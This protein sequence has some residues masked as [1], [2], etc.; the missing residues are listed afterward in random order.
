MTQVI[1]LFAGPGA[2]KSTLATGVFSILKMH[3]VNCEYV[4]EYA[5][6]LVWESKERLLNTDPLY[7]F[8]KQLARQQKLIDKV[9]VV[10]TDSPL[11]IGLAYHDERFF[12]ELVF[13]KFQ[14]YDNTNYFVE[15]VK[16]FNPAG[17]TQNLQEAQNISSKIKDSRLGAFVRRV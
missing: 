8:A 12:N 17:R 11:L 3:G 9:D 5:K 7:I 13:N 15:R 4:S 2:G 10:I 1:N 6:D 14:E 16:D